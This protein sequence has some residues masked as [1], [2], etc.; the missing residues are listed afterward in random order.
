MLVYFHNL[1]DNNLAIGDPLKL[2]AIPRIH[3]EVRING[4][5]WDV[6]GVAHV[7]TIGSSAG[8]YPGTHFQE[9]H[10]HLGAK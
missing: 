10:I 5:A 7:I 4:K 1:Y 2:E 8:N 6:L 9:V 3:E